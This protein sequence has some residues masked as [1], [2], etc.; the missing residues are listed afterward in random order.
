MNCVIGAR[1]KKWPRATCN[2]WAHNVDLATMFFFPS[3]SLYNWVLCPRFGRL[4]MICLLLLKV[5]RCTSHRH[6]PAED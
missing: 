3:L 6:Q 4:E 5:W 2:L 1:W